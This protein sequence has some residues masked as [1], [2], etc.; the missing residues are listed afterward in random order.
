MNAGHRIRAWTAS[1]RVH[2][3]LKIFDLKFGTPA[4]HDEVIP[5][6]RDLLHEVDS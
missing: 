2:Y 6:D 1:A 3:E 4:P 5:P